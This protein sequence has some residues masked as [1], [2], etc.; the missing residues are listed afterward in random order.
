MI[1]IEQ[2]REKPE[3]VKEQIK[4]LHDDAAFARVDAVIS[5]DAERRSLR[6]EIEAIQAKRNTLNKSMGKL[7]GNKQLDDAQKAALAV[8]AAKAI[9][10]KQL[11]DAIAYMECQ[12]TAAALI[13]PSAGAKTE[14]D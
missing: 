7:R 12:A 6:S 10:G 4:K 8:A 5:L 1:D 11:D 13:N 3:W 14:F 9:E 2:I